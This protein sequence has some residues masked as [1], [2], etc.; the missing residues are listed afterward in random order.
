MTA[1][2][3]FARAGALLVDLDG[4]LV[5]SSAP[6]R[7][8]WYAFAAR[9][10]QDGERVHR[11]AQGRPSRETVALLAPNADQRAEAAW[12]E[13][14]EVGDTGGV[15][16]LPGAKLLL[17][18]GRPLAIVTSCSTALAE[19]R[20]AAAG[21]PR[22]PVLV[23]SD[24]LRRGKPDPECFLIAARLLAVEPAR[25]V[26]LEDSPT[27][28]AAGRA[29]GAKVIALRTTHG[30]EELGDADAIVDDLA[31]LLTARGA[32]QA[33]ASSG[34]AATPASNARTATA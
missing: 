22:P 34:R 25:C 32:A 20:L 14:I 13:E 3:L 8:A 15:R 17:S 19:A 1:A 11:F 10:G 7:R 5:D 33:R 16:A 24:G 29:A 2:Q 28:I 4:T 12:I 31:A 6:V 30:D 9:H 23:S 27:G 21:L 26:V 18:S